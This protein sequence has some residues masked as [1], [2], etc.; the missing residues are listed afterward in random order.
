MT[1][2]A[3]GDSADSDSDHDHAAEEEEEARRIQSQQLSRLDT[4]DYAFDDDEWAAPIS[5]SISTSIVKK[6]KTV[7]ETLPKQIPDTPR[8]RLQ[9]LNTLHPEFSPLAD[10]FLT[11]HS[12]FPALEMSARAAETAGETERTSAVIRKWRVASAYLGV[13]SMYFAVLGEAQKGDAEAGGGEDVVEKVRD[14]PVMDALLG[15]RMAWEKVRGERVERIEVRLEPVIEEESSAVENTQ[16]KRKR[17][18]EKAALDSDGEPELNHLDIAPKAKKSRRSEDFSDL[19][20]LTLS[21]KN[22][23][24]K[25]PATSAINSKT[26]FGEDLVLST[27]DAAEKSVRKRNLRFYSSQITSKSSKRSNASLATGGD[28]DIPHRE[29]RKERELRLQAEAQRRRDKAGDADAERFSPEPQI[30]FSSAKGK[31]ITTNEDGSADPD[32]EYYNS[33]VA[34]TKQRKATKAVAYEAE[35]A[36]KKGNILIEGDVDGKRDVGWK[37]MRN[38]GLTPKRRKEVRNPRVKKKMQ[39]EAK[40]KKVGS[41]KAVYKGGLKGSYGGEATGIKKNLV[42]SIKFTS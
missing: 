4:A 20:S 11:L 10:E 33:V 21:F 37:I 28:L 22:N 13:L 38:K 15:V 12:I 8:E 31:M 3:G 19:A 39:Y 36:A 9:L 29:R 17:C 41:T 16:T 34:A 30:E 2:Y 18:N 25:L 35:K 27:T 32:A 26:D 23:H 5:T 40:M 14:H 7:K 1:Y 42:K 24:K 6:Q